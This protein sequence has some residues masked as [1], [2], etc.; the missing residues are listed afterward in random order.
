MGKINITNAVIGVGAGVVDN[1]LEDADEKAARVD[2]FK[3][4][5]FWSRVGLAG[6]GYA[7]QV[8]GFLPQLAE[9]LAQ[10]EITL[11]TKSAFKAIKE[12][13]GGTT[14][15]MAPRARFTRDVH[16]GARMGAYVAP[17][18]SYQMI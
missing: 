3:T 1:L 9:P 16:M 15:A 4:W 5:T 12:K 18:E 17:T 13:W 14:A 10:S 2:T 11:V 7:G 6:I 8:W